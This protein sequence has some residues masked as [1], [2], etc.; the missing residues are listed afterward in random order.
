[1]SSTESMLLN[2]I[3]PDMENTEEQEGSI[4]STKLR[5]TS[6][7]HK[8]SIW[9]E[10]SV[11]VDNQ[12]RLSLSKNGRKISVFSVGK[13][14][15]KKKKKTKGKVRTNPKNR[16]T[17]IKR[18]GVEES[19]E[20][21]ILRRKTRGQ[22]SEEEDAERAKNRI[23]YIFKD[24]IENQTETISSQKKAKAEEEEEEVDELGWTVAENIA[25]AIQLCITGT[26]AL[27]ANSLGID[28]KNMAKICSILEK[29]D[30]IKKLSLAGNQIGD[31]GCQALKELL[32]T[33]KHLYYVHLWGNKIGDVGADCFG[34]ALKDNETM[35][36]LILSNNGIS[37]IGAESLCD[38]LTYNKTLEFLDI[39]ENCMTDEGA[40]RKSVV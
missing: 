36:Y 24:S 40:D 35:T 11:I 2:S 28:A 14:K 26:E 5:N 39:G 38:G 30:S 23:E 18:V 37:E 25:Q 33:T 4:L 10:S 9:N 27:Q 6:T 20:Q 16:R 32:D 21:K 1:M 7:R 17:I 13:R 3:Q 22:F 29:T 19:S 8:S 34:D 15:K 12:F 31:V